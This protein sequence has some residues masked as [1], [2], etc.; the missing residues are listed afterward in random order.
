[1]CLVFEIF[2]SIFHTIF[3]LFR[4]NL[5]KVFGILIF[6]WASIYTEKKNY[7][8]NK[9]KKNSLIGKIFP[10]REIAAKHLIVLFGVGL[11]RKSQQKKK[12]PICLD[13]KRVLS[14]FIFCKD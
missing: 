13:D 7:E 4:K 12:Q 1:M 14:I 8:G 11:T 9:K 6:R 5:I 2:M 3:E 10:F